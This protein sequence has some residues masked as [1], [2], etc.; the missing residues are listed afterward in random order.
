M[1]D[2]AYEQ[3]L[4]ERIIYEEPVPEDYEEEDY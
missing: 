2:E 4:E 3:W 1:D